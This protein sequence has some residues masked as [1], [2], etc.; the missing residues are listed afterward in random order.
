MS[1][2][3][4]RKLGERILIG[5][6]IVVE[7]VRIGPN[8]VRLAITAPRDMNIVREELNARVEHYPTEKTSEPSKSEVQRQEVPVQVGRGEGEVLSGTAAGDGDDAT[9]NAAH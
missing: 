3:L 6:S 4:S 5:D 8:N 7:V 1:L 9:W 2:V